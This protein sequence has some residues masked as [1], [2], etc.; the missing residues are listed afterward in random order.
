MNT[1]AI[2]G[3]GVKPAVAADGRGGSVKLL[4]VV[5]HSVRDT[6]GAAW[7]HEKHAPRGAETLHQGYVTMQ[8]HVAHDHHHHD[9]G[10]LPTSGRPLDRVAFSATLHC[11]TGCALGEIAGMVIGTAIGASDWGTVGLAVV[12]AFV[13]GYTLTS[14]P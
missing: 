6:R 14:W 4:V 10:P 5:L 7:R 11:L 13:F 8:G 3:S 1:P 9:H 12:L 2:A